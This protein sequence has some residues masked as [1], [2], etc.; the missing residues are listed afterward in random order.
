[1]TVT[2]ATAY[3]IVLLSIIIVCN[4]DFCTLSDYSN[5]DLDP[6]DEDED[7]GDGDEGEDFI[8]SDVLR[9]ARDQE[10]YLNLHD[11]EY[12]Y[13]SSTD[14]IQKR[15]MKNMMMGMMGKNKNKGNG[16]G[17]GT[18][19]GGFNMSMMMINVTNDDHGYGDD[20]DKDDHYDFGLKKQMQQ[21]RYPNC[22]FALPDKVIGLKK[23]VYIPRITVFDDDPDSDLMRPKGKIYKAKMTPCANCGSKKKKKK[24]SGY[25]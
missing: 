3:F 24:K 23:V 10:S 21:Q 7:D 12:E 5:F 6:L 20:H 22:N 2:P 14:V 25:Y 1:M 11:N 16:M 17:T 19:N 9:S 18:N 8:G 15:G 13:V 4:V